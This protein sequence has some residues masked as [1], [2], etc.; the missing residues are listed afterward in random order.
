MQ[1]IRRAV[2]TA[3]VLA[4]IPAASVRADEPVKPG[5]QVPEDVLR[6]LLKE[7]KELRAEVQGLK[8][9]PTEQERLRQENVELRRRID[10]LQGAPA[11][12]GGTV[13]RSR[14]RLGGTIEL[15]PMRVPGRGDV[16]PSG[17]P[18]TVAPSDPPEVGEM[19]SGPTYARVE[20][21]P[22]AVSV[23]NRLGIPLF[24]FALPSLPGSIPYAA[25][26]GAPGVVPLS[27]MHALEPVPIPE[28]VQQG[29]DEH[30]RPVYAR[31]EPR[32]SDDVERRMRETGLDR[33]PE[34]RERMRFDDRL[35]S[36]VQRY[37]VLPAYRTSPP[38]TRI[39]DYLAAS[40]HTPASIVYQGE[41]QDDN[42]RFL[43]EGAS[44]SPR[45]AAATLAEADARG[46]DG[47]FAVLAPSSKF[48]FAGSSATNDDF[49]ILQLGR[50]NP[51]Q[52]GFSADSLMGKNQFGA[53]N[54]YGHLTAEYVETPMLGDRKMRLKAAAAEYRLNAERAGLLLGKHSL[55]LALYNDTDWDDTWAWLDRPAVYGRF[56]NGNLEALGA[57]LFARVLNRPDQDFL[58][59]VGA[60]NADDLSGFF[61]DEELFG[62]HEVTKD[63]HFDFGN[64]AV[65]A[66]VQYAKDFHFCRR[67]CPDPLILQVGG[68]TVYGPNGTGDDGD[69]WIYAAHARLFWL[70][71]LSKTP[72]GF[73]WEAEAMRR[74]IHVA[75]N[76]LLPSDDLRDEGFW[77]S[78]VYTF[79]RM[80]GGSF[81]RCGQWFVGARY[82]RLTGDGSSLDDGAFLSRNDDPFRDDRTR[83]SA[84]LGW[85]PF[86]DCGPVLKRFQ[87][88]IQYNRDEAE[89]LSGGAEH[90]VLLGI[91]IN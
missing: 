75:A 38:G 13:A 71:D 70:A 77:T 83:I 10:A 8:S 62:G 63:Q 43:V 87:F 69:T 4:C 26:R 57:R 89:H 76:G 44:Q 14:A 2:W 91:Q 5:V 42:P 36:F 64:V 46:A 41:S 49:E 66:R 28:Y 37:G 90:S 27:E 19:G 58:V 21:R 73:I 20:S 23:H 6:E 3:V 81:P 47:E 56:C 59:H 29:N 80:C 51:I 79:P 11:A 39:G 24:G 67:P 88:R 78:A 68:S 9:A 85:T 61:Q 40:G 86:E 17:P 84:L 30:G 25:G 34:A 7:I 60:Y 52:K 22:N 82:E 55:P 1:G 48:S 18:E 35:T 72:E 54:V 53:G 12:G 32:F 31:R 16:S 50:N 33:D 45:Y 65:A 15:H 74:E